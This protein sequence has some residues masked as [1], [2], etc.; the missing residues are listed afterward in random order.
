MNQA[1]MLGVQAMR[2]KTKCRVTGWVPCCGGFHL[3]MTE[4]EGLVG[5]L[6][7]DVSRN[8]GYE[9]LELGRHG[10][11]KGPRTES[12][13]GRSHATWVG[14][15]EEAAGAARKVGR[16]SKSHFERRIFLFH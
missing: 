6:G 8:V 1:L 5:H 10:W 7:R 15:D 13:R 9:C 16:L 12:G 3:G 11:E 4:F 2:R 14:N